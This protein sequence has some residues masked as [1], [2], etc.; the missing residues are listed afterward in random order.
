MAEA[1]AEEIAMDSM[2]KLYGGGTDFAQIASYSWNV[3]RYIGDYLHLIG[4]FVLFGTLA[5]NR[6]CTGISRSTCILYFCV[7]FTRYLDL[8]DHNQTA[9]LVFFKLTYLITSLLVLIIFHKLDSTYERGKDTCS[10]TIIF[11]PCITASLLLAN[12]YSILEICWTL[13][14]FLEG[15]AMVPQYIFCYRDKGANDLGVSF[16]VTS[17]GGYRVFYALNWIYK[18]IQMPGYSDIQSW[19][20][21][22]IEILFFIDFLYFRFTGHSM[23]RTAVLSVDEKVNEIQEKV[24]LKVLGSS[25]ST[26]DAEGGSGELRQR[27]GKI[28]EAEMT[29][30]DVV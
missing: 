3:F 26:R 6:A 16:Y 8:L 1:G 9:Y 21:G 13:S 20:G 7:F 23:L 28:A 11:V 29:A 12:D 15:F 25:R 5:K 18:K 10:L 19:I 14:Q 24:E 17:H 27:R 30:L 22:I 2:E 4:I